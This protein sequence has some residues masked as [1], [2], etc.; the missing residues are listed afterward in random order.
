MSKNLAIAY[1]VKRRA[2]KMANGDSVPPNKYDMPEDESVTAN[3]MRAN[4]VD[5][6][7]DEQVMRGM[8]DEELRRMAQGGMVD[9]PQAGTVDAAM[10]EYNDKIRGKFGGKAMGGE[11]HP[12]DCSC[13]QCMDSDEYS[14]TADNFLSDEEHMDHFGSDEPSNEEAVDMDM[15]F[16]D[17]ELD[18]EE[19]DEQE[20]PKLDDI[21]RNIRRRHMGNPNKKLNPR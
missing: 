11:A 19:V 6:E 10:D 7:L 5:P 12:M 1:A 3:R 18:N 20:M 9:S 16:Q 14:N 15:D 17:H 2:K 13:S 4:R 8:Q 21:I